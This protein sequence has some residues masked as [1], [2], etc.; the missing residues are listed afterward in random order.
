VLLPRLE[1]STNSADPCSMSSSCPGKHQTAFRSR[2]AAGDACSSLLSFCRQ[3]RCMRRLLLLACGVPRLP[4]LALGLRLRLQFLV[5][6]TSLR[7]CH[8]C[9][10]SVICQSAVRGHRYSVA[11]CRATIESACER[12]SVL[13]R[14][15]LGNR[16]SAQK[17]A[18][19]QEVTTSSR[20]QYSV[21]G[22]G[23]MRFA[24]ATVDDFLSEQPA[25]VRR[26]R[27]T[28]A[29]CRPDSESA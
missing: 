14:R 24:A 5:R 21:I 18:E 17:R 15:S 3:V 26:S 8:V 13:L 16:V 23:T 20:N 2:H 11:C 12:S 19:L 1:S 10:F 28:S 22:S 25:N 4:R 7:R 29:A 27:S 6:G 9:S